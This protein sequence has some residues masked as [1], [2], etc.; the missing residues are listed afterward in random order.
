MEKEL[1]A[2]RADLEKQLADL[3]KQLPAYDKCISDTWPLTGQCHR[4]AFPSLDRPP[5]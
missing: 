1:A 2:A 4:P 5:R 3:E